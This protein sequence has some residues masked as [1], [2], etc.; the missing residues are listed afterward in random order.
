MAPG[1]SPWRRAAC[2][3]R[4]GSENDVSGLT[5]MGYHSHKSLLSERSVKPH[6]HRALRQT[7]ENTYGP[8]IFGSTT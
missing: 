1:S 8:L 6:S 5:E 4:H 3:A 7:L 2:G